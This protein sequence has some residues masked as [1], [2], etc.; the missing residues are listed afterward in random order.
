MPGSGPGIAGVKSLGTVAGAYPYHPES[1]RCGPDGEPCR[2]QTNGLL[3][4]RPVH[5]AGLVCIG[6]EAHRLEERDLVAGLDEVQS[7][8]TDPRREPWTTHVLPR[9]RTLA[10]EPGGIDNL[11]AASRLKSRALR[12]VLAGRSRP[13]TA[14][15]LALAE[16]V[17]E[18]P[19]APTRRCV[20]CGTAIEA[21]DSRQRYCSSQCRKRVR[22]LRRRGSGS[23]AYATTPQ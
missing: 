9:L 17:K 23:E 3:S 4:R 21:L 13:R 19:H 12:D 22:N 20:G 5:A 15:R 6:K 1:K 7:V 11:K 14:A 10:A 18:A 8:F 2:K 16:L